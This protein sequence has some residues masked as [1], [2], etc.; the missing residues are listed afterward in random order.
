MAAIVACEVLTYP[1]KCVCWHFCS[2]ISTQSCRIL[3]CQN[4]LHC[5]SILR[6]L[7]CKALHIWVIPSGSLPVAS[8]S[9]QAHIS[10]AFGVDFWLTVNSAGV[11]GF[12][13][14]STTSLK[15]TPFS[16]MLIITHAKTARKIE[17]NENLMPLGVFRDLDGCG[18]GFFLLLQ[19]ITRSLILAVRRCV[20]AKK[21]NDK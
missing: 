16:P 12:A 21:K 3:W 6:W 18:L 4:S 7:Q 17:K 20:K 15:A 14:G 13:M 11:G 5:K 1:R 9:N 2:S 19:E 10:T 8:L